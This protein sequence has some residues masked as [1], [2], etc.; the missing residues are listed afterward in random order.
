MSPPK[1]SVETGC[2]LTGFRHRKVLPFRGAYHFQRSDAGDT[3]FSSTHSAFWQFSCDSAV[4]M[5]EI[6]PPPAL[7]QHSSEILAISN[8]LMPDD[9]ILLTS[10]IITGKIKGKA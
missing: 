6:P 2:N 5:P 1:E 9:R 8:D 4:L 3:Y 7:L 10:G